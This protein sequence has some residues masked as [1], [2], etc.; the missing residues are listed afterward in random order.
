MKEA[1]SRAHSFK[2][3]KVTTLILSYINYMTDE[4]DCGKIT[5]TWTRGK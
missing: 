4:L 3:K 2:K 1:Q 5:D